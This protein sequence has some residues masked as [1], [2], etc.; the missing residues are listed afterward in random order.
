[1]EEAYPFIIGA[2]F[3]YIVQQCKTLIGQSPHFLP[4]ISYGKGDM[5]D[6]LAPLLEESGNDPARLLIFKQFDLRLSFPE[7]GR[8]DLFGIHFFRFVTSAVEQ[9]F[10]KRN[11]G[12]QI[13]DGNADMFDFE[14][15]GKFIYECSKSAQAAL[16]ALF[17]IFAG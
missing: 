3:G 8:V 6:A 17:C 14:H 13:F 7:E 10:E 4:Y 9:P 1:M 15:A 11:R 12:S 16:Y 2:S 5:V